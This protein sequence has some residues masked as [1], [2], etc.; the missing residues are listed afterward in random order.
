MYLVTFYHWLILESF[1][2]ILNRFCPW[3]ECGHMTSAPVTHLVTLRI[4]AYLLNL[5][6]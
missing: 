6:E 2:L 1:V 3:A 5:K 4:K